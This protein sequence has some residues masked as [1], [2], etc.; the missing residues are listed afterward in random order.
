MVAPSPPLLLFRNLVLIVVEITV[1]MFR[2][3]YIAKRRVF[4]ASCVKV[5]VNA[6]P[7]G[8]RKYDPIWHSN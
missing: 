1:K 3:I 2:V 5:S 6:F 4:H 8:K 7:V